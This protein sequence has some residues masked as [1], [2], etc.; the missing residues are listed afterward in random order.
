MNKFNITST[1]IVMLPS[2]LLNF[3]ICVIV[4]KKGYIKNYVYLIINLGI[5]MV[6]FFLRLYQ[7]LG[8]ED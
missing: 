6:G 3:V 5:I 8:E 4:Q 7:M 1:E 2:N